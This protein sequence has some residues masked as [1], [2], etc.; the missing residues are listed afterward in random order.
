MRA[1]L[2]RDVPFARAGRQYYEARELGVEG[3]SPVAVDR[4]ATEVARSASSFEGVPLT[5]GHPPDT[6]DETTAPAAAVGMVSNVRFDRETSQLRGDLLIWNEQAIRQVADG[7]RELSG[8]YEAEYQESGDGTYRQ[9]NIR[10]N[11]VAVVP[12]G[13]SGS[14]QRIG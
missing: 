14:A 7:V 5:M 12:R 6:L 4:E 10:G 3:N 1:K 11:H 9:A 8:G 2:F 13:R